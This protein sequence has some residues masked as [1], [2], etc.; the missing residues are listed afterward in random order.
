LPDRAV[1][2]A[3][4]HVGV[5]FDARVDAANRRRAQIE[6]AGR[7]GADQHDLAF[8]IGKI[9]ARID[10][11]DRRHILEAALATA[12]RN[13]RRHPAAVYRDA[14]R[15]DFKPLQTGIVRCRDFVPP[16]TGNDIGAAD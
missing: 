10:H 7:S 4:D 3:R 9:D 13:Q 11:V 12:I 1:E 14:Q 2:H 6:Q 16:V 8:Q 5:N 15:S